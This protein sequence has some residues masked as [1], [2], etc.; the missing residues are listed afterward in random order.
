MTLWLWGE[1]GAD[2]ARFVVSM[3]VGGVITSPSLGLSVGECTAAN[4]DASE[5]LKD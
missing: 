1:M 4:S 3:P 5:G 2:A